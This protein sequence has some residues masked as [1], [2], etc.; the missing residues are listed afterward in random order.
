MI[1][2]VGAGPVGCL[3]AIFLAKKN[4]VHL[5]ERRANP[6]ENVQQAQKS[7]NLALS[8]RGVHALE[9]AGLDLARRIMKDS[10]PMYGRMLHDSK[11]NQSSQLYD[12][13]GKHINAVDR[14]WLN[15][16][17]LHEAEASEN[18]HVHYNHRFLFCDFDKGQITFLCEAEQITYDTDL[19]IGSDG[20][21]S[22]VRQ[23]LMRKVKMDFS[24]HY[25]DTL[26]CELRI[27]ALG[28]KFQLHP[29]RL[30]IWP[31][32]SFMLIALPNVD[33]SFTCTLFMPNSMFDGIKTDTELLDLFQNYFPDA[34]PLM[35]RESLIR[36]FFKNEKSALITIKC[37]PYHYSS[38]CV[39]IGDAAHAQI[40]FYGQGMNAGFESVYLLQSLISAHPL[41]TAVSKYSEMRWP[42]AHAIC[43][44]SMA[45]HEEMER[46][47]TS[48]M[49]LMRKATE[50]FLSKWL[51]SLGVRTLYSRVSFSHERY[52]SALA[53]AGR[54]QRWFALATKAL[55]A[56]FL[57]L[58]LWILQYRRRARR[59]LAR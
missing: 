1:T 2:I 51:P 25:I 8:D 48:K 53:A 20:A 52:S 59:R 6:A 49:Y 33:G 45:N 24:Q 36:D 27:P 13:Y 12:V 40:P 58:V 14:G 21:H 38:K 34:I 19:I 3:A 9:A 37:K 44:L 10:L 16:E 39:I 32:G 29:E 23:Q 56:S 26:Y 15:E 17:L 46:G 54:Q 35:G 28:G 18:V 22:K 41:E 11:G 5:F 55:G 50:E 43:D 57:A 42:D 30:H 47:V 31:R 4:E 7:I